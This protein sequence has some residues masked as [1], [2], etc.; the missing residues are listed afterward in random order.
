MAQKI[1]ALGE[2]FKQMT[3]KDL[4][5]IFNLLAINPFSK[6][7][8]AGLA[9]EAHSILKD[10]LNTSA[11][12]KE[13]VMDLLN[14]FIKEDDSRTFENELKEV[15]Y[16]IIENFDLI[17]TSYDGNEKHSVSLKKEIKK[18]PNELRAAF[19]QDSFGK[20]C[21]KLLSQMNLEEW[22]ERD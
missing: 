14:L 13:G 16:H 6:E 17:V 3:N 15:A 12:L 22:Q 18:N 4:L 2:I 1:V 10:Q 5:T 21:L 19:A 7:G 9:Q 11:Y 20:G 8:F